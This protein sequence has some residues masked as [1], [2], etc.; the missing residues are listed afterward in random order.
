LPD[1]SV[2][3]QQ[4]VSVFQYGAWI[5]SKSE[6]RAV[7]DGEG[8]DARSNV[9]AET[10]RLIRISSKQLAAGI[11]HIIQSGVQAQRGAKA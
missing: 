10:V 5:A 3:A 6:G 4:A 2:E 1:A 8:L 11:C 9:A 7:A